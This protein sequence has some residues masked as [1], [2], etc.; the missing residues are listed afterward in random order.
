MLKQINFKLLIILTIF[1]YTHVFSQSPPSDFKLECSTGGAG[2]WSTSENVTILANGQVEF[3]IIKGDPHQI[4]KDTAFTISS[5]NVQQ[6]WSA[7]QS[8]NFFSLNSN[9]EDT[10]FTD[11][12]IAVLTI[13]ANGSSKQVFVRNAAMQQIQNIISVVNSTLPPE[14]F[15][16]YTPPEKVDIIP[17]E[18]CSDT[19][20][21][22]FSQLNKKVAKQLA[23][24]IRSNYHSV[25]LPKSLTQSAH[26]GVEIG[27][28][29]SLQDAI[30]TGRASLKSKGDFY[31]DDVSITGYNLMSSAPSNVITIKLNLEFYGP[32]DNVANLNKVISDIYRKWN[33]LKTSDGR[34]IKIDFDIRN[35]PDAS[36]PP[37]TPGFDDIKLACGVGRSYCNG[38]GSP[39]TDGVKGGVWYPADPEVG[40][41]GHEAGH[42]M[43]L[44]DQYV[45]WRRQTDGTWKSAKDGTILSESD[46][47]DLY[48]ARHDTHYSASDFSKDR[49]L[50]IPNEG[51]ENDLMGRVSK[52]PAQADIDKLAGQ[53]G[54]IIDINPGDIL[55]NNN[56][57]EQNLVVIKS[58]NLFLK[59]GEIKT[60]NG[61]Y[62]AC[63]DHFNL[64]PSTL[65]PISVAPPLNKWNGIKAA[66]PLLQLVRYVDSLGY[67]CNIYDD[68]FAQEAVWRITDNTLP[69]DS[70]ADSLL[71]RA[72]IDYNQSFDFPKMVFN[73][74]DSISTSYVPE[75]LFIAD[76]KP[77]F[78]DAKLNEVTNFSENL[79]WPASGNY[80]TNF[81]WLLDSTDSYSN[82]LKVNG[83]SADLTPFHRGIYSLNL[84]INVKDSTGSE[85]NFISSVPSQAIVADKYT[86]T[87]EHD[88]LNDQFAWTTYGDAPWL[89]TNTNSQTGINSARPGNIISGQSSTLEIIIDLPQDSSITFAVKTN[90]QYGGLAFS[91]DDEPKAFFS[92]YYDWIFISFPLSA[93]QHD[94]KWDYHYFGPSESPEH[95][96]WIDNIFFPTSAKMLTS[97]GKNEIIPMKFALYQNYP[98]PFNPSTTIQYSLAEESSVKLVLYDVQGRKIKNLFTGRQNSG[99]H[100]ISFDGS[101]LSSGVY[102]YSIE[103]VGRKNNFKDTKKMILTK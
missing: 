55:I 78:A 48:N 73:A 51:H 65:A 59:P 96:I 17:H 66:G 3:V 97:T 90:T 103:A 87:F 72:G 13:T 99:L 25:K 8:N 14:D 54:L 30:A 23:N 89:I 83:S 70:L 28:E 52:P 15:L 26:G 71:Y 5:A 47:A 9:Y 2:P 40:T 33:G 85:R 80:T 20:G 49:L 1:F 24:K 74:H 91:V 12:S 84:R 67:Y 37:G 36:S 11:G 94:L 56:N 58:G 61:I 100:E 60:L 10:S 50:G 44:P 53:A 21:L 92:D 41:F 18:P 35:H 76:I 16:D 27:Y 45:D 6:I 68:Y 88:N 42:L 64:V 98:N 77:K 101:N 34:T 62:A 22:S 39:N 29:T 38:L 31:G 7:V 57:G 63:I 95:G 19:S 32:C 82:Q 81:T 102:F 86:E 46:F 79:Y 93:G 4:L 43:G 69:Y 75:Q